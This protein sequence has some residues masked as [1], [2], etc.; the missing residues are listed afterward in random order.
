MN[1]Y[2]SS[3][4]RPHSCRH[5]R[6]DAALVI[7][8]GNEL[9]HAGIRHW[10]AHPPAHTHVCA[11]FADQTTFLHTKSA[12]DEARVV[13]VDPQQDM[14]CNLVELRRICAAGHRVLVFSLAH[15]VD[16]RIPDLCVE[17]GAA[18][19]V[20]KAASRHE[21]MAAVAATRSGEPFASRVMKQLDTERPDVAPLSKREREV[22]RTWVLSSTKEA[23]ARSMYLAIGTVNTHLIRARQKYADA[24][25][26]APTK[27]ELTL[28]ALEDGIVTHMELGTTSARRPLWQHVA[29]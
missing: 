22:V 5:S 26:P 27:S 29:S 17:S 14:T 21:F 10:Y 1:N 20:S 8:D 3:S 24:G 2:A 18:T 19:Y 23:V 28:R 15:L 12:V 11:G 7:I 9:T 25:R 13:V 4:S 16:P 6:G